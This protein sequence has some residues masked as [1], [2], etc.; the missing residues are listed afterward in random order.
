MADSEDRRW[1]RGWDDHQQ[2]QLQRLARLSLAEKLA[3]LEEAHAI[4]RHLER[5]RAAAAGTT[6]DHADER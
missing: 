6:T 5:T 1:T 3:W 2:A 4:V